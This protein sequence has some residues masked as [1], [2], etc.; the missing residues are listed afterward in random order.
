MPYEIIRRQS[1][2]W[3]LRRDDQVVER[4]HFVGKEEFGFSEGVVPSFE[5]LDAHPLLMEYQAPWA[6]VY[7]A[8]PASAPELVAR[9]LKDAIDEEVAPWRSASRYLNSVGVEQLLGAGHGQ[10]LDAPSPVVG[11]CI[12]VLD[13]ARV[14]FKRLAGRPARLS[15]KAFIAGLNYVVANNFSVE[16]VA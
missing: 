10:I 9:E 1:T 15:P 2:F 5:I 11:V 6:M 13:A 4:V 8:A 16:R 7:V 12:A 3:D 14:P